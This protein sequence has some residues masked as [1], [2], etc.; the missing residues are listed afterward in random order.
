LK[1]W[2][3]AERTVRVLAL[4][5]NLPNKKGML[6]GERERRMGPIQL[7]TGRTTVQ[8]LMIKK[9]ILE[10]AQF[11]NKDLT[12][13]DID[14]SK[15]YD[16]TEKFAKEISLRRLGFPQEGLDL[17]QQYDNTR[18]MSV[19][20][21]HGLTDPLTPECGAWGQGAPEA[22]T[23]WLALMCWMSAAVEKKAKAPYE[24][25]TPEGT[26]K[27]N[28][29][30]YAD[31]ATYMSRTRSGG[32]TLTTVV[33]DFASCTG[34]IIKPEKSYTYATKIIEPLKVRMYINTKEKF[35][36]YNLK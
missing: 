23:G 2:E 21:A 13:I 18:Q 27:T 26:L 1:T 6:A 15:A 3:K 34:T 30:I 20:T 31:D 19:L 12:M 22:P 32:Q 9:M 29:C 17:W 5:L 28:K 36:T 33:S 7:L 14:F 10:D 8:P 25:N 35:R 11:Y 16:S 4:L 24:Y